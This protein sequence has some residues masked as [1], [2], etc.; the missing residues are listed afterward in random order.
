MNGTNTRI[1]GEL[2]EVYNF[3]FTVYEEELTIR[4][5]GGHYAFVKLLEEVLEN[6]NLRN[7]RTIFEFNSLVELNM[8]VSSLWIC[9]HER[10]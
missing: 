5:Y 1:I 8:F 10:M 4:F 6:V 9:Y 2:A 3:F 7:M